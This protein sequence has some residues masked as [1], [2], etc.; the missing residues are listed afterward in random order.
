M[1]AGPRERPD[2]AGASVQRRLLPGRRERTLPPGLR[3]RLNDLE[4]RVAAV[5]QR[6][7]FGPD[8]DELDKE[9]VQVLGEKHAAADA[10]D[11]ERAAELRDAERRLTTEKSAKQ[12]EWSASHPD[13]VALA[14]T[15]ERVE[16]EIGQMR[17]ELRRHGIEPQP[18]D[19]SG[20]V[21]EAAAEPEPEAGE[22]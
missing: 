19:Q 17:Q 18:D 7:G 8:V 14:E 5:E 13:L 22:V 12:R 2:P 20:D 6:V 1:Q 16:T 15:V 11:Y 10:Q 3:V 21:A 4:S 9:I